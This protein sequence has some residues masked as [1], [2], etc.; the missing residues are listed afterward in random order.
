MTIFQNTCT[1]ALDS[2]RVTKKM[3]K[4]EPLSETN[5]VH[6][7]ARSNSKVNRTLHLKFTSVNAC[8]IR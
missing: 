4:S 3:G 1:D 7:H 6:M 8:N 2:K 5:G